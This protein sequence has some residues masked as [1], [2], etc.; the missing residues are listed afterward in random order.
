MLTLP[1]PVLDPVLVHI[2]PFAIRWYALAYVVS[3]IVGWRYTL[4]LAKQPRGRPS[5]QELDD[6]LL[7]ATLGVVLGGRI[8]Y[9]LFYQPDYYFSEPLKVFFLWQGGMSFHGG[10]I[11]VI[12]A[13]ALFA[14]KRAI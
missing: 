4:W 10:L 13:M 3:L 6:F 12:L 8:G 5:R 2:G 14:W 7:W 9:I 11:G 1:F